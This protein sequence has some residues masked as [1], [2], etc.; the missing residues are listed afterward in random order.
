MAIPLALPGNERGTGMG[1]DAGTR[2]YSQVRA[3]L[4][5]KRVSQRRRQTQRR[6]H[7]KGV[8][9]KQ[10]CRKRTIRLSDGAFGAGEALARNLIDLEVPEKHRDALDK[11]LYY[12]SQN[13]DRMDYPRYRERGIQVGSGA[14][15]SFHR[16]AS[17]MRLKLAGARWLPDNALAIMNARMMMLADRWSDFWDQPHLTQRLQTAFG[18]SQDV[19]A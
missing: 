1:Q 18:I 9:A 19:V 6:G 10:A 13:A 5:G 8:N 3:A 2:Q 14:M 11:L 12:V 16:V 4:F 7:K 17:Q 15:E